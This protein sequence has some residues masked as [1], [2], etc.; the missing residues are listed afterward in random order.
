MFKHSWVEREGRVLATLD[1]LHRGRCAT[2]LRGGPGSRQAADVR[3]DDDDIRPLAKPPV[4]VEA[5][6]GPS[7]V[8]GACTWERHLHAGSHR[9][10]HP[11][12]R[13][14]C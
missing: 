4:V 7:L 6:V 1:G 10:T 11:G 5:D 3:S 8:I 13:Y 9:Q 12:G 2:V 14:A